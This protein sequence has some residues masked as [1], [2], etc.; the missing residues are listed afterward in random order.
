MNLKDRFF[1]QGSL[2]PKRKN[3]YCVLCKA[4][5]NKHSELVH[6]KDCRLFGVK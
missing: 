5:S 3:F 4:E 6:K 1:V 2:N